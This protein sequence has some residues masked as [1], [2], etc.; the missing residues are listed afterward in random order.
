[1][2]IL[3]QAGLVKRNSNFLS[4]NEEI[5]TEQQLNKEREK[6]QFSNSYQVG[7]GYQLK[8]GWFVQT[9]LSRNEIWELFEFDGLYQTDS[10]IQDYDRAKYFI[11]DTGDTL[12]I[13]GPANTVNNEYR[14]V[15][16]QNRFSYY[17]IPLDL[18]YQQKFGKTSLSFSA[19]VNFAF[20]NQFSGRIN[21]IPN[22][23]ID[24]PEFTLKKRLGYQFGVGIGYEALK[25]T[26]LYMQVAYQKSPTF[27]RGDIDQYYQS[28]SLGVGMR[29]MIK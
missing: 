16:H 11:R 24:N 8:K 14:K 13:S 3:A 2:N 23:I 10:L 25:N 5:R 12:F 26:Q 19:G 27:N 22:E 29:Y 20:A 7:L 17:S 18:G 6:P 15:R 1:M 21:A 4:E 9:G 28:Y